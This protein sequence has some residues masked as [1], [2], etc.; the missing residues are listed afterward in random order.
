MN[1]HDGLVLDFLESCERA[2]IRN[3]VSFLKSKVP[4]VYDWLIG[5]FPRRILPTDIDG[6]VELNCQFLRFEFKHESILRDGRL[7]GGQA[8]LFLRLTKVAPFTVFLI[9]FNDNGSPT[10][11]Q[12]Y[13]DGKLHGKLE[14][15]DKVGIF[16][17]CQK[18]ADWAQKQ[19]AKGKP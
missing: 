12:I 18:W 10:C 4:M 8:F 2:G 9:G 14:D 11:M 13:F 1:L 3:A 15:I 5:A 7:P 19:T 6:E 17:K 16:Q